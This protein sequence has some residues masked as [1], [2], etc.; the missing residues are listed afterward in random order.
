M[1]P[2]FRRLP[3]VRTPGIGLQ[4]RNTGGP[5]LF[6]GLHLIYENKLYRIGETSGMNDSAFKRSIKVL[7]LSRD[8]GLTGGVEYFVSLLTDNLA[9]NIRH[10]HFRFGQRYLGQTN[11]SKLSCLIWDILRFPLVLY[12][13][14]FDTVCINSSLNTRA[15]I[16][17]GVF[18]FLL[19]LFPSQ[20]TVLFIHGWQ[21]D[22]EKKIRKNGC[23]RSLFKIIFGKPNVILVLARGFKKSLTEIGF[24]A[25]KIEVLTTM[26]DGQIFEGITHEATGKGKTLLFLS[27]FVREKGVYELIDAFARI[28]QKFPGTK[29]V[30]AGDGPEREDMRNLV[31]ERGLSDQVSFPGYVRGAAK[32]H[33]LMNADIFV[34]PTYYGEGCPISLLEAMAAGLAVITTPVGGVPDIFTND[35]NGILLDYLSTENIAAAIVRLLSEEDFC[36]QVKQTNRRKAWENFEANIVTQRIQAVF[37]KAASNE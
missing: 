2:N 5:N 22:A 7:I 23:L 9:D 19:S 14:N 13:N 15:L 37:L 4:P 30:M 36:N 28:I 3:R 27:R 12:S 16:R 1:A 26:F 10:Q 31:E 20:K 29:L 6:E 24:D 18:L 34:L 17:D 33:V 25:A 21:L 11:I 32:A 35:E 8:F